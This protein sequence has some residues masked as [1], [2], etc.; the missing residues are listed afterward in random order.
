MLEIV[1]GAANPGGG[2]AGQEGPADRL[3][4]CRALGLRCLY[5]WRW[6]V[7]SWYLSGYFR[8]LGIISSY[9]PVL[10]FSSEKTRS[11]RCCCCCL[12]FNTKDGAKVKSKSTCCSWQRPGAR[13]GR[14]FRTLK[15]FSAHWWF[16][17]NPQLPLQGGEGCTTGPWQ[18]TS[19]SAPGLQDQRL[20]LHP[21]AG[22][23]PHPRR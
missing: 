2:R 10:D 3:A 21:G 20:L 5:C 7:A 22:V 15:L 8:T 14:G 23:L 4:A 9:N 11:F 12:N 16:S 13:S 17:T 6:V 18:D 1:I 19:C